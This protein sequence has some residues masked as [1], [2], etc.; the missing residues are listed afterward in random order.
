MQLNTT[1]Q[2]FQKSTRELFYSQEFFGLNQVAE[3]IQRLQIIYGKIPCIFSKGDS[4]EKVTQMMERMEKEYSKKLQIEEGS[5]EIDGLILLDRSVDIQTP[6]CKQL[7][8]IGMLDEFFGIRLN[9]IYLKKD[10]IKG[11]QSDQEL[12]K[13]GEGM[14]WKLEDKATLLKK[15]FY[16][17]NFISLIKL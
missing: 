14:D 6:L 4:A 17:F 16:E 8:Y 1:A 7:T 15:I 3:S 13:F 9:N 5:N 2:E 10:L 11:A 12:K